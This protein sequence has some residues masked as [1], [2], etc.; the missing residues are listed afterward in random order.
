MNIAIKYQIYFVKN[1]CDIQIGSCTKNVGGSR[2]LLTRWASTDAVQSN[3]G[4]G[5]VVK[6][7]C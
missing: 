3:D 1:I 7:W 2:T 6:R 4:T 5:Y